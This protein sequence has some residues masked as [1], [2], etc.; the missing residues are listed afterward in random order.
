MTRRSEQIYGIHSRGSS[1]NSY[2]QS[3]SLKPL[4]QTL[5][6]SNDQIIHEL[7]QAEWVT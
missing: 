2:N 5:I 6:E 7:E 1:I 3:M 4:K